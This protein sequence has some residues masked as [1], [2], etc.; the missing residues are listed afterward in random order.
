MLQAA[1]DAAVNVMVEA[2]ANPDLGTPCHPD[3]GQRGAS[4]MSDTCRI[5]Y[6]PPSEGGGEYN[7]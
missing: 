5:L 2:L 4:C 3:A 7:T 6:C 1:G